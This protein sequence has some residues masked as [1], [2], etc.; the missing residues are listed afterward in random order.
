MKYRKMAEDIL[1]PPRCPVCEKIIPFPDRDGIYEGTP[2]YKCFVHKECFPLLPFITE[3][4][5]RC[6][7]Q[8]IPEGRNYCGICEERNRLFEEARGVFLYEGEV[9]RALF[10]VKYRHKKE[11]CDFFSY[12]AFDRLSDWIKKVSPDVIIPV[13]VHKERLRK[14]GYNQ[15]AEFAAGLKDFTGIPVLSGLLVRQKN[16]VAQKELSPLERKQNLA[17]AFSVTDELPSGTKVLLI[18]DIYTTGATAE[19]CSHILKED[20]KAGAVYVLCIS[21]SREPD[22]S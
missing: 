3:N 7:G 1:F 20:G 6:C 16:T 13:P 18:D 14:R 12:A 5:C 4:I 15:A 21:T 11:Y 8:V 22:H 19:T 2:G 17:D 10:D 9:R